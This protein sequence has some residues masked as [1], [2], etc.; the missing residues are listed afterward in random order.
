MAVNRGM[1]ELKKR[2]KTIILNFSNL[3]ILQEAFNPENG[4]WK[5]SKNNLDYYYSSFLSA[6]SPVRDVCLN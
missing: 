2:Y 4:K 1:K 5:L 3:C 6:M